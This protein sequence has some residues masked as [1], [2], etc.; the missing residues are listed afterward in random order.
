[1]NE[2][3]DIFIIMIII[4]YNLYRGKAPVT[5]SDFQG[6]PLRVKIKYTKANF[7]SIQFSFDFVNVY[8]IEIH[9]CHW[10]ANNTKLIEAGQWLQLMYVSS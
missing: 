5:G 8:M 3:I 1:M 7:N 4:I 9:H 6:G 10:P 2:I